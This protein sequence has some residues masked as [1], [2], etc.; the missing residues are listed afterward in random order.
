MTKFK[1]DLLL[2]ITAMIFGTAFVS[3]KLG[4][5]YIGPFTFGAVR[6]LLGTI[7]LLFII[8]AQTRIQKSSIS[9]ANNTNSKN[10]RYINLLKGGCLCGITLFFAASFQ[11]W[12]TRQTSAGKAGFITTL[13]ILLVPLLGLFLQKKVD[14]LT[15]FSI[16]VSTVGLYLL[17]VKSDF[18]IQRGDAIV[19]ISTL[20]WAIQILEVDAF[21]DKVDA[22][23][24]SCV[25]FAT[26]ATL[27]F[28]V[29]IFFEH[30][31]IKAIMSSSGPILYNSIVVI[32][33]AFTFQI[34]GQ[35]Y[36]SPTPA[37]LILST[38]SVFAVISGVIILNETL[39]LR[40]IIGCAFMLFAI[41]ITQLH[42]VLIEHRAQES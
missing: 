4:M 41:I 9:R 5:Q 13:Y 1:G 3:Q 14:K 6:F 20:F 28:I 38:E 40:E 19:L 11:Q 8:Y 17:C 25:Q 42:R 22:I 21:V 27:S 35:K 15:W 29:A 16:A 26:A 31:E 18:S 12:G 37:A 7:V 24:L 10:H 32:G 23:K 2:L 33:I 36:T 30:P 39:S 34:I